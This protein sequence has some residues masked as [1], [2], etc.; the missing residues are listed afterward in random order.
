M[1]KYYFIKGIGEGHSDSVI[2]EGRSKGSKE[3]SY[4]VMC[5]EENV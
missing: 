4:A 2:P 3:G 5:R 1:M